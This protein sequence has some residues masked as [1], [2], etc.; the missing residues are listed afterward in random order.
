MSS[1]KDHQHIIESLD[2]GA[3]EFIGKPPFPE[4]LYARLRAGERLLS[5]QR[6]LNRL[7]TTDPLTGLLNRR[8][9][10]EIAKD[11]CVRADAGSALTAVMLDI[12]HFKRIN[13]VYGHDVGDKVICGVAQAAAAE[14]KV[15]ARLG[16]EEYLLL[17]EG[18]VLSDAVALAERIRL[19]VAG[20]EFE[21]DKG[22]V[23]VTCSLGVSEWKQG[24]TIDALLK[25]ADVAL[26][27]AKTGGRNRVVAADPA[28][29]L[30][31]GQGGSGIIRS[32]PRNDRPGEREALSLPGA[33]L[34]HA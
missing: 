14:S 8:A 19:K 28:A 3:D 9:C 32:G 25:G 27:A 16:G 21:S 23:K 7:A 31:E 24:D 33:S 1:N 15:A 2:G 5:T 29:P 13:D 18:C 30:S 6:A 22:A 26:Y 34:P 20:L 4:E 12:D 11:V 10:F 17:L